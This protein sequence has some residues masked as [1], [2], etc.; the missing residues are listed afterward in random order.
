MEW[1]LCSLIRCFNQ[2]RNASRDKLRTYSCLDQSHSKWFLLLKPLFSCIVFTL[3]ELQ[4]LNKP[5]LHLHRQ[6]QLPPDFRRDP[7]TLYTS[8]QSNLQLFPT[9]QEY[10]SGV[11]DQ[12]PGMSP[13]STW[14]SNIRPQG[15]NQ[16]SSWVFTFIGM[17]GPEAEDL[18][19]D[20]SSCC[21]ARLCTS[22][23]CHQWYALLCCVPLGFS[24]CNPDHTLCDP[25]PWRYNKSLFRPIVH[26]MLV[27]WI[28]KILWSPLISW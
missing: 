23:Q 21:I 7:N 1:W 27:V 17:R 8:T 3:E 11:R 14:T 19:A 25:T 15:I 5:G 4:I 2:V 16:V 9:H 22:T 26:Q 18:L 24:F 6:L 28:V 20:A 10:P 12:S 13:N